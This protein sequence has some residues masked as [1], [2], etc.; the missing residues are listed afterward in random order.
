MNTKSSR[1]RRIGGLAPRSPGGGVVTLIEL[2][3]S[4]VLVIIL[5]GAI[6]IM[7]IKTTDAFIVETPTTNYAKARYSIDMLGNDL[8]G[9][10]SF[11]A[12]PIDLQEFWMENG[13]T[14][15]PGTPPRYKT[16]G[17]DHIGTAADR[18]SFRALT[19]VADTMQTVQVTWELIPGNFIVDADGN[20]VRGDSCGPRMTGTRRGLYSLVRRVRAADPTDPTQYTAMARDSVGVD[21]PDSFMCDTVLSFNIEYLGEGQVWSQLEPSPTDLDS[22]GGS[23][24][25]PGVRV[26]L[27]IVENTEERQERS[28]IKVLWIPVGRPPLKKQGNQ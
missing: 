19:S 2:L 24:R 1:P 18:I 16:P 22:N 4:I 12:S 15:S 11:R 20:L 6:T 14:G 10:L 9:C 27:V 8:L 5:L 17:N 25:V 23:F 21:V 7:C 3:I 13:R 28:F 26:T